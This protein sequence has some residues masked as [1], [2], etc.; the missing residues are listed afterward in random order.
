M[1]FS[2]FT[3]DNK[4]GHKTKE[5][6]FSKNH[7]DEYGKIISYCEKHPIK[8]FKEKIWFYHKGLTELPK[9][10]GCGVKVP[11]SNRFDRGYNSFC[12]L[13]CANNNKEE[14][15][16]R[17]KET[18][19]KKWGVEFYT[20]HEDFIKKQK[21]TKKQ[22]YGDENYCNPEKMKKTKKDKYGDEGYNNNV[23]N[24]ITRRN[25]FIDTVKQKTNDNF[26]TYDLGDDNITLNCSICNEDYLIYN[27]LFNYRTKQKSVLCTK[28]NPTDEKQV[29]G[30][31][32]DLTN[33]ISGVIDVE[34]KN[35]SVLNGKEIDIL[36]PSHKLGVEFN[37]LYWHSDVYKENNYHLDKTKL[38]NK[39]NYDLIHVF[40]D[41]WLEKSQIV[42]SII[43]NR[44][45]VH[46][47]RV[48]GR[49]C[50]MKSVPKVD[51]KEFLNNNH[52]QGFVGSNISYGLY[53]GDELVSIMTFGGL[54]KS[55]GYNTR[56]GSYEML[57]FCNKLNVS[58]VGGASK[59]F[60]YF[61]KNHNPLNVISYSD[62]RYFNGGLYGK[63]GFTY[64]GET[65][66]NYFYVINHSRHNRYKFRKDVLIKGGYNPIKTEKEIMT[67]RG[68]N[69]IYDCGNKRW[70]FSM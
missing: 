69:R 23:K 40:E 34:T 46:D 6:W 14:L 61:I 22:R 28:C 56:E 7:P 26:I 41:E 11:F 60:S 27:N 20:Q 21:L 58:V 43:K 29:S 51:E 19:K 53:D 17:Q 55:L 59:L 24:K 30:L 16:K 9:C 32:L 25:S 50:V 49:K 70:V 2:F 15:V 68:Y 39:K 47:R 37:G 67:E 10:G 8:T 42:K 44:L 45:G 66:P 38:A 57:R 63:L 13:E 64:D 54:R 5:S 1:D 52:I 3:T 35:R 31:E 62:N 4:S 12:S 36:I 48:Y 65:R 18:N 33:F